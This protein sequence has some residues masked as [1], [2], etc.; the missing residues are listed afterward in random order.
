[1]SQRLDTVNEHLDTLNGDTLNDD[2][3]NDDT[4][5]GSVS[6]LR[7]E[8]RRLSVCLL[9]AYTIAPLPTAQGHLGD[10]CD[11]RKKWKT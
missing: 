1:M 9:K 2:T 3:L 4:L 10:L 8:V 7:E 6:G 11:C 5:N